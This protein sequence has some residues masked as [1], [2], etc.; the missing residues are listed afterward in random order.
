MDFHRLARPK[1]VK[2]EICCFMLPHSHVCYV[3]LQYGMKGV[4]D[5]LLFQYFKDIHV[6]VCATVYAKQSIRVY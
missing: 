1:N 5:G 3:L 2:L 6:C 4:K